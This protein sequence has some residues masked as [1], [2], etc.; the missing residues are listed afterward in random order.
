MEDLEERGGSLS[1]GKDGP[2]PGPG[3][4][5]SPNGTGGGKTEVDARESTQLV[6]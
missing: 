1:R 3:T 5:L 6:A 2:E 4:P